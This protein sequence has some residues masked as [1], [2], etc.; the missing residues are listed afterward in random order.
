MYMH[1][2][3]DNTIVQRIAFSSQ[4]IAPMHLDIERT[5]V[6]LRGPYIKSFSAVHYHALF[7]FSRFF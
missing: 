2:C 1:R 6:L 5:F 7:T 4:L 3:C